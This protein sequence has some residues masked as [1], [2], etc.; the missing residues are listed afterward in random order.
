MTS[1]TDRANEL[2]R[3]LTEREFRE[4]VKLKVK[5]FRGTAT[6]AEARRARALDIRRIRAADAIGRQ[7]AL[8]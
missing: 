3:D 6:A 2:P 4:M 7:A 5:V 8:A 1:K